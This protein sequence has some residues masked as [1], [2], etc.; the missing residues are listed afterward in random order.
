[1][2]GMVFQ[3]EYSSDNEIN[4]KMSLGGKQ[5]VSSDEAENV[6]NI[7]NMQPDIWA[8]SGAERPRFPF[9][10][11]PHINILSCSLCQTLQK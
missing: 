11:Q 7:S 10:G 1:M 3:S 8:N 2:N 4:V 6:S 5:S 9:T